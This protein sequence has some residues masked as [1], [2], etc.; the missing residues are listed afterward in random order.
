MYGKETPMERVQTTRPSGMNRNVVRTWGLLFLTLGV[1]GRSILQNRLL[2]MGQISANQLM[3]LM[4]SS[5]DAMIIATIALIMQVLETLAVPIFCFLLVEGFQ[6]TSD[7]KNY[8][9][10]VAGI[11]VLSEI[12]FNLAMSGKVLDFST[13]NP[14]FGMLVALVVLSFYKKYEEKK[15]QNTVLKLVVTLAGVL[16]TAML[17]VDMGIC[18]VF[19]VA[20]VW[21]FRK[22]PLFRNLSGATA[23]MVCSMV[24]PFFMAAPMGFL[25]VHFYNGE[26]GADSRWINY[27]A[28][29]VILLSVALIGMFA[30]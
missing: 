2:G 15:M 18:I 5:D 30:L 26:K 6:H 28:Y 12:P 13:R 24:S 29:P 8:I 9:L 22:N 20:V 1:M 3:E 25:I 11:A 14:V 7:L 10:R 23:S 21:G 4:N 27:L 19:I 16:W 17:Q